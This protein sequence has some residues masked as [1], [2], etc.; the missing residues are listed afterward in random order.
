LRDLYISYL[1]IGNV[2]TAQGN[3]PDALAAHQ[4]SLAI[5]EPLAKSDPGNAGRQY[6]LSVCYGNLG[7]VYSKQGNS[8]DE[9]KHYRLAFA[10]VQ[11]LTQTDATK[12]NWH[13]DLIEYTYHLAVRGD[14]SA[15]RFAFVATSL[16]EIQSKRELSKEQAGWLAEAERQHIKPD[17]PR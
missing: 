7:E 8:E 13:N 16:R 14:Q 1:K 3:L 17:A 2:H 11:Q 5:M 9:I 15:D 6:D 10:I 4:R 12:Q